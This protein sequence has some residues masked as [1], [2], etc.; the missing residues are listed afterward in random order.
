MSTY[1]SDA[2]NAM[3]MGIYIEIALQST[4]KIIKKPRLRETTRVSPKLGVKEEE[5]R[6]H[7]RRK[8]RTKTQDK[9]TSTSL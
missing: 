5:E 9:T 6:V 3:N 8:M 2:A 7:T 4:G 1:H